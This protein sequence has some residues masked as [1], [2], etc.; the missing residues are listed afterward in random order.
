MM[1]LISS[2]PPRYIKY[3]S[4]LSAQIDTALAEVEEWSKRLK[5]TS[6][7]EKETGWDVKMTFIQYR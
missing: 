5:E 2:I 7:L 3:N 4:K 1:E 6:T